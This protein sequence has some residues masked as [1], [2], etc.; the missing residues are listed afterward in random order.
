[1]TRLGSKLPR[2]TIGMIGATL[3]IIIGFAVFFAG[4]Y[5]GSLPGYQ[6]NGPEPPDDAYSLIG[7]FSAL[8]GIVILAAGFLRKMVILPTQERIAVLIGWS[9][10]IAGLIAM[11]AGAL[12]ADCWHNCYF[13]EFESFA[14]GWG[15][16]IAALAGLTL[17]ASAILASQLRPSGM[18]NRLV[19]GALVAIVVILVV[20]TL[21]T[22]TFRAY[23][24]FSHI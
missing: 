12:E 20:A 21:W 24:V 11:P 4:R 6:Y 19:R 9:V 16:A 17:V 1:M 15:G 13:N 5:L 23:Y 2:P 10:V 14:I 8:V 18:H 7:L 22:F 3:L